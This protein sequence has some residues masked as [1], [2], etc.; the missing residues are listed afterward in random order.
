MRVCVPFGEL[1][2]R[3]HG[4]IGMHVYNFIL[5][6]FAI[7]IDLKIT[8]LTANCVLLRVSFILKPFPKSYY[9]Y[10]LFNIMNCL[11]ILL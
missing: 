6:F 10:A 5:Y 8:N 2:I 3:R 4:R 7:K 11:I 9:C 1:D